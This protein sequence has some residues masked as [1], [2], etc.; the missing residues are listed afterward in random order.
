LSARET[1][2][3]ETPTFAATSAIVTG[4]AG[5]AAARAAFGAA[6]A[7]RRGGDRRT[8]VDKNGVSSGA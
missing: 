2:I 1:V 4:P 5:R 6:L 3:F 7:G 8:V